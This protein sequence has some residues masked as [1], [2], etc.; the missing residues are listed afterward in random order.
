MHESYFLLETVGAIE[1]DSLVKAHTCSDHGPPEYYVWI[2]SNIA[3]YMEMQYIS[4]D[5]INSMSRGR[6]IPRESDWIA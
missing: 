6:S 5:I 3:G 1:L 2:I 4:N